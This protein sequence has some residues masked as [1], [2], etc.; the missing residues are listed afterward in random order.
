MSNITSQK[1]VGVIGAGSF[2]IAVAG[3]IA[4]N[5]PVLICT[6]REPVL[7]SINKH[8]THL[9]QQL[10]EDIR[11]TTSMQEVAEQCDLIFPIVSSENFREM[12]Q[13]FSTFLHPHHILI[14]GTKGFDTNKPKYSS[15]DSVKREGI[16]TMSEIIL[17]ESSVV[18][19]GCLSGPNLAAEIFEGQP[20]ATVIAS[21]YNEVI[22]AGRMALRSSRFQVYSTPDIT[23]AELAGALKNIIALGA[24]MLGGKGLG[25]NIWALFVT[26]G[27]VE[28]IH[29]GKAMGTDTTAFLGIAGIGD[30]IA[31]ASS[32]KSRNYIF[33]MRLAG[34]E[35]LEEIKTNTTEIAEGV[36]TLKI[37]KE[38]LE[39]YSYR[40]PIIETLY[41]VV[42][43]G[44]SFEEAIGYL[45][46]YKYTVDVDFL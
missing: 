5:Y 39:R 45:M 28:M 7:A 9:G 41:K 26:R 17:Q 43:E 6:R 11:A 18:R 22:K 37:V 3:L 27:L 30:L 20:A 23:G 19:V 32:K 33:G 4:A 36:R 24:G 35:S 44:A 21:R 12:M 2:G 42:F 31:T 15:G 38:A 34:G 40:A 13:E 29:I 16:H 25:Q 8:H 10:S 14:H 1:P 46:N